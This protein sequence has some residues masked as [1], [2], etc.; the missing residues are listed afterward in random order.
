MEKKYCRIGKLK[1]IDEH[2]DFAHR[3][4]VGKPSRITA[5]A[6]G[7]PGEISSWSGVESKLRIFHNPQ[8]KI[9]ILRKYRFSL[10]DWQSVKIMILGDE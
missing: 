2:G 7:A 4:L 6:S 3:G 1:K 8:I 5:F 10:K 9:Y